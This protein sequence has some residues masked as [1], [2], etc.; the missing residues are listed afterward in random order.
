MTPGAPGCGRADHQDPVRSA[1][2]PGGEPGSGPPPGRGFGT[3][4]RWASPAG[5][6]AQP[7]PTEGRS[8]VS[9]EQRENL[10]AILRQSAFPAGIEVSEQRRLLAELTS[11][12][13]LPPA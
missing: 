5:C 9:T 11:A 6:A 13:P 12:Q 8:S 4:P 1:H 2:L 7:A 10:E 3:G